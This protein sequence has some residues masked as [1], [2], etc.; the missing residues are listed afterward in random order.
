MLI[1]SKGVKRQESVDVSP[2][3]RIS[4]ALYLITNG[5]RKASFKGFKSISECLSEE[6]INAYKNSSNRYNKKNSS[7]AIRKRAE[8]EKVAKLNR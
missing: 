4:Q 2:Y 1:S 3:R 8:I 7:Y 5:A 6:L